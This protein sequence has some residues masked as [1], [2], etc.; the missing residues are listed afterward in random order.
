MD[1]A[2]WVITGILAAMMLVAGVTKATQSREKL[3]AT[4]PGM[5][6]VE[7]FDDQTIKLLGIAEIVGAAGLILPGVFDIAPILVPIAAT[8]LAVLMAGAAVTHLRRGERFA[9]GMP[10][11][12]LIAAILVAVGRFAIEPL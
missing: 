8:C 7:D 12:L 9:I 2:L 3:A 5:A 10:S 1:I 4:G 6:Y 11:A